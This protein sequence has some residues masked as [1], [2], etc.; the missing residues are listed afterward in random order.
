[1][2]ATHF[3]DLTVLLVDDEPFVSHVT[4]SLLGSLGVGEVVLAE[5]GID[6]ITKLTEHKVDLLI[7]DVQM[8]EMNGI[9]LIKYIRMG[10]TSAARDLRLMVITSF[11]NMEVLGSCLQLDINGFLVKPITAE[12]A[13]KKIRE[14]LKEKVHVRPELAYQMV[15]SDLD[16][17]ADSDIAQRPLMDE[18][19]SET[20]PPKKPQGVVVPLWD[21]EPG[22]VVIDNIRT[23]TGVNLLTQGHVL[24]KVLINRLKDLQL[25]L[26]QTEI[27]VEDT[28]TAG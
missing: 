17:L 22:M 12:S 15:K 19:S 18:S 6:A 28:G 10:K 9:E 25:I 4:A 21:L 26:E 7:T 3:S 5:N 11:S 2:S 16:S 24:N 8:P 20:Q 1:M 14:S 27:R 13:E 23:K